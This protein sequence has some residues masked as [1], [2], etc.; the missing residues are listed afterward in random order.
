MGS[1]QTRKLDV[2]VIAA[3]NRNLAAEVAAGRFREDLFYRLNVFPVAVPPL[4][5]RGSDVELL[6]QK[7]IDRFSARMGKPGPELTADCRRRLRA[8]HWPGNVRE[9]ENAIERAVI[10]AGREGAL[11]LRGVLQLERLTSVRETG[12]SARNRAPR[13]KSELREME[14]DIVMQALERAGWKVAGPRGAASALGVPASTLA[15]RHEGAG[16]SASGETTTR[17]FEVCPRDRT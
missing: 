12:T 4:R 1:S 8:Y 13:T 10:I 14:R 6:A 5:D 2:R 17:S 16:N 11:S 7:F 15:S 3:S 9:L